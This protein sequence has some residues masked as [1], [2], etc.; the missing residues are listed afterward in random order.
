MQPEKRS[1]NFPLNLL[2][3]KARVHYQPYG[4]VG[5]ISPWNFPVNLSIGP[6][7][8][9]FAAGNA[10]MIKLSEFVP[11][12]SQLVENLIKENFS[13]SEVVVI[14][15]A[16]QTSIDFTKLPFDHL[17][18]TG[19]TDIAKKV[20]TTKYIKSTS[21]FFTKKSNSVLIL[22]TDFFLWKILFTSLLYITLFE[23][24]LQNVQ[25]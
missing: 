15:G 14:N 24:E 8:D 23:G 2:G 7:V 20:S 21:Y 6:L 22:L 11:R 3:A 1:P 9:A 19:S 25:V 5:I 10:A 12:T 13:E 17:I 18:Y 4:V 16:M